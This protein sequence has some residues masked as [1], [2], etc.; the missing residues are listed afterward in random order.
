MED[1]K[2]EISVI[3][4]IKSLI[5]EIRGEKVMLDSDV[6]N[7]YGY[8]TKVINQSVKRNITRFSDKFCFKL[9]N[10]EYDCLKS[11]FVTSNIKHDYLIEDVRRNRGGKQKLP[12]VFTE[13][14][15]IMLAGL[16][17]NDIAVEVSIKIIEAFVE[18]RKFIMSNAQMFE[19][20]VKV[21]YKLLEYD[22]KFNEIFDYLQGD[23]EIK[24]GIFFN[25]Q[26]YDA[27][28]LLL[29]IISRAKEDIVIIDN[30]VDKTILDL[31]AKKNKNVKVTIIGKNILKLSK[32]DI[33]K[34]NSQYPLL[35]IKEDNRFHDR[36]IIIDHHLIYHLGAS[37]KDLG[38]KVFGINIIEDKS[39]LDKL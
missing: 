37:L 32:L 23:I 3:N 29:D 26:I 15:V 9:T 1:N 10:K 13:K 20:M 22:K 38:V 27:H 17:K 12:N 6:A 34:F 33:D 25:G 8:D 36:F 18:M 14:G 11:H 19:R 5:Y 39:L 30:Y 16:L 2:L 4:D 35:T 24:L 21:E 28:S 7:L 31:L